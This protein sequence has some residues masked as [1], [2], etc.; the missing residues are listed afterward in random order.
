MVKNSAFL[1]V[2]FAVLAFSPL[3]RAQ[4]Q[5]PTMDSTLAIVRANM[6]ADRTTLI[7]TEMNFNE[8]DGAAFWPIYHQYEYE[9]TKLDDRRSSVVK[10]YAQN[11]PNISDAQAKAMAEE[12]FDCDAR[13][14]ALKVKYFK[15]FNKVL[16]ALTVTKFFQLNRRIDLVMDMQVEASLPLL[17]R[18]QFA[19]KGVNAAE[20]PQQ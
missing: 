6:Q 17:T 14:A 9:R 13:L 15:K 4:D 12:M 2:A 11:Y 5:E 1:A 16:P 3:V 18:A 19:P 8:K 20:L 7:T 10:Q